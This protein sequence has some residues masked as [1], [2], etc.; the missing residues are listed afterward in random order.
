MITKLCHISEIIKYQK[1]KNSGGIFICVRQFIYVIMILAV[2]I[3][4]TYIMKVLY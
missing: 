1:N 3:L 2:L 4:Y